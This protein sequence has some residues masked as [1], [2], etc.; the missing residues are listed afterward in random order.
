M[1]NKLTVWS[2]GLSSW[3]IQDGNY[4]NFRVEE[5]A[6]FALH[7]FITDITIK[8]S[9]DQLQAVFLDGCNYKVQAKVVY[10]CEDCWI[11]DFGIM[12]YTEGKPPIGIEIGSIITANVSIDIDY[13]LYT[14]FLNKNTDIQP[15]IYTWNIQ[16]I[17]KKTN[18]HKEKFTEIEF[19]DAW[20]DD[21]G[22]ASYLLKCEKCEVPAK[23]VM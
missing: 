8:N 17:F 1:D 12:A 7:I 3:V 6:E 10:I 18:N 11:I 19:I 14:E 9:I 23:R 5:T 16:K 20:K 4:H 15:L 2:I 13:Y 22:M 21:K